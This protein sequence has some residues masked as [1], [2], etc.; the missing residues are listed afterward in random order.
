MKQ[1]LLTPESIEKSIEIEMIEIKKERVKKFA[2][3]DKDKDKEKVKR[4]E[5]GD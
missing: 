3:E 4:D 2:K 5:D 1:E